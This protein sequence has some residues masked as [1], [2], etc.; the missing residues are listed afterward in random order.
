MMPSKEQVKEAVTEVMKLRS[1]INRPRGGYGV[2]DPTPNPTDDALH[3]LLSLS[4]SYLSGEIAEVMGEEQVYE[5]L[6]REFN[7]KV[8]ITDSDEGDI[9]DLASALAGKVRKDNSNRY[10][11][12]LEKI[13]EDMDNENKENRCKYCFSIAT[14]ALE[15]GEV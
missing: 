5:I 6:Q 2:T 13:V 15:G 10:R 8:A 3:I 12:A 7:D 1:R 14:N 11:L 4:Q 9:R